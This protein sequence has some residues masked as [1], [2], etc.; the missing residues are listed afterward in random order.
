MDMYAPD[1]SGQTANLNPNPVTPK[2]AS[3]LD[4]KNPSVVKVTLAGCG[5]CGINL[6]RPHKSSNLLYSAKYFD[7]SMT[8]SRSGEQV[9]VVTNGSGSGGHRAENAREIES[10]LP[11]ISDEDL[12]KADVAVVFFSASGGSGAVLGSLMLRE[13][14]RRGVRVI[15][16]VVTDSSYAVGASNTL[17][18]LKTLTAVAKANGIYLPLI[19]LSNDNSSGRRGVDEACAQTISNLIDM[20]AQPVFEVD[21]NDRL[22]WINPTKVVQTEPGI[23]LMSFVTDQPQNYPDAVLGADSQEMVDALLI[24]QNQLD[25]QT[26]EPLTLPPARLKKTGFYVEKHRRIIGKVS[27]DISAVEA[28]IDRIDHMKNLDQSQK[29]QSISRLADSSNEEVYL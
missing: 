10:A 13:Y 27:S 17:K 22:N 2:D 6:V 21:R 26:R 29:H 24:L 20:L 1:P 11:R 3:M 23:R 4:P 5:G 16:V 7:T 28:V 12:G 19:L 14:A 18:T 25:E 9:Y 8:N 15:A